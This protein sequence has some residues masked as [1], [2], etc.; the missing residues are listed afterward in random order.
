MTNAGDKKNLQSKANKRRCKRRRLNRERAALNAMLRT[1]KDE[2]VIHDIPRK[3]RSHSS[4]PT[5]TQHR[6]EFR[7]TNLLFI[8]YSLAIA[9]QGAR[10]GFG[11]KTLVA[12]PPVTP[13]TQYEG[14]LLSKQEADNIRKGQFGI[15][16]ASHF[17]SCHSRQWIINGYSVL[18]AQVRDG[19]MESDLE[20]RT[21][22]GVPIHID[23]KRWKGMGGGSLCNHSETPNAM[24]FKSADGD[25]QDVYVVSL[26]KEIA[27]GEFIT[28]S[29]GKG[30]LKSTKSNI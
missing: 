11:L 24:L 1:N 17:V 9:R 13:I 5:Y 12:I 26:N 2:D 27:P 3:I 21:K 25:C 23:D 7:N 15:I 14:I 30:F 29:Y 4:G 6:W 18:S 28:V 19:M 8:G 20:R 22:G 16:R 10:L